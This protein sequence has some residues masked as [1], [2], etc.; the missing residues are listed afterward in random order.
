MLS[1]NSGFLFAFLAGHCM[2]YHTVPYIGIAVSI[3]YL[4]TFLYFPETP[5]YLLRQKNESVRFFLDFSSDP[6]YS[7]QLWIF[8][9]HENARLFSFQKAEQ[10]FRFYRNV[11]P[12]EPMPMNINKDWEELRQHVDDAMKAEQSRLEYK[13]LCNYSHLSVILSYFCIRRLHLQNSPNSFRFSPSQFS[14]NP[15]R[16]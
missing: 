7:N 8:H 6:D 3:L 16:P 14:Q 10:S 5:T 1:A 9:F 4:A 11:G 13:D 2:T 15:C 12:T